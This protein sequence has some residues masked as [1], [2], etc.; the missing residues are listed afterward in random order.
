VRDRPA[1]SQAEKLR[2]PDLESEAPGEATA[3]HAS[4][5][6]ALGRRWRGRG[7]RGKCWRVHDLPALDWR[8][9]RHYDMRATFITLAIDDGADAE[10]LESA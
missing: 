6:G 3:P 4:I 8:H 2:A 9:R 10:V 5:F 1:Y 7:A